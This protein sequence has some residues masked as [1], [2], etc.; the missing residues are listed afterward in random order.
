[1]PHLRESIRVDTSNG[2]VVV[3]LEFNNTGDAPV[4]I[5]TM[6]L[7]IDRFDLDTNGSPV[8]YVGIMVK[9]GP[10]SLA[11]YVELAPH[12][13]HNSL[14]DI[15]DSYGFKSGQHAYRIS[16]SSYYLRDVNKLDIT[17]PVKA[18]VQTFSFAK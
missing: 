18:P 12:A 2:R 4:F 17:S 7:I 5:P 15:T 16:L 10:L 3:K 13:T 11:D 1:M 9:R 6:G 8:D 14:M